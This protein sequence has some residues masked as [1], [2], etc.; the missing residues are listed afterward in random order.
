[1]RGCGGVRVR[2]E[3][4]PVGVLALCFLC[5]YRHLGWWCLLLPLLTFVLALQVSLS[6][7]RSLL[8][9]CVSCCALSLSFLRLWRA[10]AR[11]RAHS[12]CSS[13]AD[14]SEGHCFLSA[15]YKKGF[16]SLFASANS[17]LTLS[18]L[19]FYKSLTPSSLTVFKESRSIGV[20]VLG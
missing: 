10:L 12:V 7:S 15:S 2:R 11:C 16:D 9:P 3:E 13:V 18:C 6:P 20:L 8:L 1:M 5:M 4:W 19:H 17:R 14:C